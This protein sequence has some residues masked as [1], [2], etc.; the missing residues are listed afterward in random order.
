[1][2]ELLQ[3]RQHRSETDDEQRADREAGHT[4]ERAN[5]DVQR[6]HAL[7]ADEAARTDHRD[8]RVR[9]EQAH[10]ERE[11]DD[12]PSGPG[13]AGDPREEQ[14]LRPRFGADTVDHPNAE[15]GARTD[16]KSTRLN[17]SHVSISYA[18]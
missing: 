14:R 5:D 6:P 13:D 17:S 10:D 7:G 2:D 3:V 4:R 12:D 11:K 1:E 9:E 8:E 18:V 15:R 16:R